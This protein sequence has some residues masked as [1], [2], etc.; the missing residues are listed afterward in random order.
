ME[1]NIK[2]EL[3][4]G[5]D[6]SKLQGY[7]RKYRRHSDAKKSRKEIIEQASAEEVLSFKETVFDE[8]LMEQAASSPEVQKVQAEERPRFYKDFIDLGKKQQRNL[9]QPIIDQMDQFVSNYAMTTTQLLGYLLKSLNSR[10]SIGSIGQKIYENK[11]DELMSFTE[12]EAVSLQHSLDLSKEQMRRLRY[13][14]SAKDAN[15]PTTTSLLPV[16]KSLRPETFSVL[17]GKGRAAD[18]EETITKTVE[19]LIEIARQEEEQ[20]HQHLK[21][22]LKDGGDG[23][24]QMPRLK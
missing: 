6:Y 10:S 21:V 12:L 19:S 24:G 3:G 8:E 11:T 15:F 7:L 13:F 1:D 2:S 14:L 16:R 9:T 4:E 20:Q 5:Y 18:Y 22:Y 23:A 17:G